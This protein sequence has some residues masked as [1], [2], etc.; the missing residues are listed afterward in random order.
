MDLEVIL[1]IVSAVVLVLF[2]FKGQNAVW[3]GGTI[4]AIIGLIAGLIMGDVV[5]GLLWGFSVGTLVGLG[6]E[7]MGMM[8]DRLKQNR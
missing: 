8:G 5:T 7:L 6:A 4:G 1:A 2:F 3:G